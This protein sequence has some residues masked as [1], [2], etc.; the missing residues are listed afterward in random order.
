MFWVT[1]FGGMPAI[2]FKI[3]LR[4]KGLQW[5]GKNEHTH[6][7]MNK[8]IYQVIVVYIHFY[9]VKTCFGLSA[10]RIFDTKFDTNLQFP[11]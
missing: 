7:H 6:A 8:D 1:A 9:C 4:F 11:L 3:L 5:H 2:S 10:A